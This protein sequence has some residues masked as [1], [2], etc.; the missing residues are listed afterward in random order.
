MEVNFKKVTIIGVGLIGGSIAK[1]L[2]EKNIKI[3]I[4][5]F[6]RNKSN[7]ETAVSQGIIDKWSL[8]L[9][10]AVY[11]ADLIIISTPVT[12]IPEIVASIEPFIKSGAIITDAGSSKSFIVNKI[13]KLKSEKIF[14]VGSHPM[15]GSEKSGVLNSSADLFV[16]S[17][18]FVTRAKHTDMLALNKIKNLWEN[19]GAKVIEI[20]PDEHDEIVAI[21]S[22]LPHILA[23]ALTNLVSIQ[24]KKNSIIKSGIANGFRDS[25]RIASSDPVMWRDICISNKKSILKKINDLRLEL[26]KMET[27][28][29]MEDAEGLYNKF[30]NAKE[31]RDELTSSNNQPSYNNE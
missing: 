26:F 19:L 16:N 23:A 29:Q 9:K 22:H 30:L 7:L 8:D 1:A 13:E 5:G 25:T 27:L 18:C 14:F 12:T 11:D 31:Y 20:S 17:T 3:K 10:E 15:A 4:F 28:I 6:G 2:K 24:N 21:T